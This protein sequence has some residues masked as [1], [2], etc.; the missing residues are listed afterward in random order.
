MGPSIT[1]GWEQVAGGTNPV[2]RRLDL[3]A[4]HLQPPRREEGLE[5]ELVT[6]AQG[7]NQSCL[8]NGNSEETLN[9]GHSES[10]Q[11]TKDTEVLKG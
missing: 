9:N 7:F 11:V 4:P 3:S 5:I 2:I 8:C 10:V 1:S 6:N